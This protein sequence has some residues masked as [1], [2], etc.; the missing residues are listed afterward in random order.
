MDRKTLAFL[1]DLDADVAGECPVCGS[2]RIEVLDRDRS[3]CMNCG[4]RLGEWDAA[5]IDGF[6]YPPTWSR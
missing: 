4:E 1:E 5:G 6:A 2:D 3:R